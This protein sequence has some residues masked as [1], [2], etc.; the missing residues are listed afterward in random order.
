[1]AATRTQNDWIGRVLGVAASPV[2][3]RTPA[4]R[5][6]LAVWADAKA[7]IDSQ[8]G[9]MQKALRDCATPLATDLADKG[10][11][12]VTRNLNVR[13]MTALYELDRAEPATRAEKAAPVRATIATLRPLVANDPL[14]AT[15]ERNPF[16]VTLTIRATLANAF[17]RI[18]QQL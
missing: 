17:D 9:Q 14:L 8:I 3:A 5:S 10:I 4:S 15:L 11:G 1:M 16:K 18:E 6:T 7:A 2:A 13:L 12:A